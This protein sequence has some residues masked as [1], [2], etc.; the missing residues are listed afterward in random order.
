[1]FGSGPWE[2][3][4]KQGRKCPS[5]SEVFRN[6]GETWR[7]QAR[8]HREVTAAAPDE[9]DNQTTG[10]GFTASRSNGLATGPRH[11]FGQS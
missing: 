7:S 10:A 1:M 4:S 3:M 6:E 5:P 9:Q 11:K 8:S 2:L